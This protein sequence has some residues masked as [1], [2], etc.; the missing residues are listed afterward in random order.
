MILSR[1]EKSTR[2]KRYLIAVGV[3]SLMGAL[4]ILPGRKRG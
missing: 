4:L 2:L 3:L 1:H